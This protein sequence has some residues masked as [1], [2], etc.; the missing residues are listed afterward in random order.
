M[1]GSGSKQC[2]GMS[3]RTKLLRA[4][5]FEFRIKPTIKLTMLAKSNLNNLTWNVPVKS[6]NFAKDQDEN[7][8]H[9]N[10]RLLHICSDTLE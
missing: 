7:H 8:S 2:G 9:V 6:E 1:T 3:W 4:Q 5:D 10:P